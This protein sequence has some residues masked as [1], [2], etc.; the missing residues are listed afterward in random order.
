MMPTPAPASV[1]PRPA[2]QFN[3][4]LPL[5]DWVRHHTLRSWLVMLFL[6]LICV[7]SITL[8][9]LGQS[10]SASTF[11]HVAWI[12]GYAKVGARGDRPAPVSPLEPAEPVA[13]LEPAGTSLAR[14]WW[15]H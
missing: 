14:P 13:P 7:P 2:R 9:F 10:P 11:D 12:Y 8:L 3:D 6:L 15:E 5:G 4:L 1:P